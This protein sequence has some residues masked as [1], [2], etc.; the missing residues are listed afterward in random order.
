MPV[1]SV[2]VLFFKLE[3]W[4]EELASREI[5]VLA[6]AKIGDRQLVTYEPRERVRT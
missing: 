1:C 2:W 3:I 5:V 6:E 4:A